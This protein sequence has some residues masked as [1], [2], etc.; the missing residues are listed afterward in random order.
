[1]RY[2]SPLPKWVDEAFRHVGLAEVPGK[3]HSPVILRWLKTLGAWWSEDETPWCGTFVAHC[4]RT[5]NLPVPKFWMRAKAYSD[6]GVS[7]AP[8]AI[9]FGAI[10]VKS[11]VGGGHVFFAVAQS[12]N[13]QI[14]YGLGGNQG[15][16]VS[17]VPFKLA[18]IDAIRWPI[19]DAARLQL[20]IAASLVDI[21]ASAPGSEA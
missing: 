1:M 9:P 21:G 3:G 10:C 18:E 8:T 20:P 2:P 7:C 14:I 19:S 13:G 17:I 5:A 16:R 6:H 4:L 15:N 12:R 11:R